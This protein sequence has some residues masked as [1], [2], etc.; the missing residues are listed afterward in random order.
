MV[1]CQGDNPVGPQLSFLWRGRVFPERPPPAWEAEMTPEARLGV[2]WALLAQ[3]DHGWCSHGRGLCGSVGSAVHRQ[4]GTGT[5][6]LPRKAARGSGV[7]RG[8]RHW[9]LG[10]VLRGAPE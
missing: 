9:A 10:C 3:P 1:S 4:S 2:A 5:S 8:R 7:R 6:H